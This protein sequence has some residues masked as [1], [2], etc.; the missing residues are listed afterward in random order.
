[1]RK[2]T[3]LLFIGITMFANTV[4]SQCKLIKKRSYQDEYEI[5]NYDY[6]SQNRLIKVKTTYTNDN[7]LENYA[8]SY[9]SSSGKSL[10]MKPLLDKS[11]PFSFVYRNDTLIRTEQKVEGFP[12]P[13][14]NDYIYKDG[15]LSL[16]ITKFDYMGRR[17]K[18]LE[19]ELFY[20]GNN[21]VKIISN[22]NEEEKR[23]VM[24]ENVKYD[25]NKNWKANN[26]FKAYVLAN[27][28]GDYNFDELLAL[29]ENNAVEYTLNDTMAFPMGAKNTNIKLSYEFDDKKRPLK[30]ID[31]RIV[32]GETITTLESFDYSC[33]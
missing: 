13:N 23:R 2:I 31:T 22:D 3:L 16:I 18:A 20:E 26:P 21:V 10:S 19:T 4:N 6:D 8:I 1:M 28:N 33:K 5:R 11:Y 25:T 27:F 29:S 30:I 15:K 7:T 12:H 24:F 17:L 14:S 9:S 32:E